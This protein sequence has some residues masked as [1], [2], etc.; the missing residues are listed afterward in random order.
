MPHP[1]TEP[2][3]AAF[4]ASPAPWL[5][6]MFSRA[7]AWACCAAVL[8]MPVPRAA[9]IEDL[10]SLGNATA[11]EDAPED[12]V[13]GRLREAL[14]LME[15]GS[16]DAAFEM[17]QKAL[18]EEPNSAPAHEVLGVLLILRD[19]FDE[20]IRSLRR[21]VQIDPRQS[22]AITKIGDVFLARGDLEAARAQFQL[23]VGINPANRWAHQRL[24]LLNEREGDY[25]A[26]IRHFEQGLIGT[27]TNYLG[28]KV[29]LGRLYNM[30]RQFDKTEQLLRPVVAAQCDV[31]AAHL[32]LGIAYLGQANTHAALRCLEH[33]R[34]LESRPEN[35]S[36]ALGIAYREAG[37]LLLSRQE[38]E[39]ALRARPG[40]PQA[41]YHLAETLLS[42]KEVSRAIEL[43]KT[44]SAGHTNQTAIANR[45]AEVFISL[46][47]PERALETY[48]SIRDRGAADLRTYD[49][50]ATLLQLRGRIS[51]AEA[52]LREAVGKFQDHAFALYRLGLHHAY[53]TDYPRA[54]EALERARKMAPSDPRILKALSLAEYRR[55]NLALSIEHAR[56]LLEVI[57]RSVEDRFYLASLLDQ[58]HQTAAAASLYHEI[59]QEAPSHVASLNNLAALRLRTGPLT[60][61]VALAQRAAD[62]APQVPAVLDTLGWVLCRAG[63]IAGAREALEKAVAAA[64]NN[65][66]YRYHLGVVYQRSD[67]PARALEE[68]ELALKLTPN[69]RDRDEATK[70]VGELRSQ[71]RH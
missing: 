23:A 45:L 11:L 70:L 60:E 57:P 18:A 39:A 2:P 5:S 27:P 33:A 42:L 56:R 25:P 32:V 36:L 55:G 54:I 20:G 30:S 8:F 37:E 29:N 17:V 68:L 46:D 50:M 47:Q 48:Q 9:A 10:R 51:E 24:G 38:L 71:L 16:F 14:R 63:N 28:I 15:Q 69:M 41:Q 19:R 44:A 58:D 12:A 65:A 1:I 61:A 4:G 34:R 66:T 3:P 43:F 21:A 59:L 6:G 49:G 53:T 52:L 35:I 7:T 40:W 26:A 64:T 67:M 31:P 13:T 62:I 22:S